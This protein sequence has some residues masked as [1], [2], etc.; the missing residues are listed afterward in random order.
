M[1]SKGILFVISGS[2]GV[3]KG[4]INKK[5]LLFPRPKLSISPPPDRC[6]P[7]E[8]DG[9][10]YYF[11]SNDVFAVKI[12][13]MSFWSSPKYTPLYG[14][15]KK[16]YREFAARLRCFIRD[17]HSGCLDVKKQM[18]AGCLFLFSPPALEELEQKSMDEKDSRQ[19]IQTRLEACHEELAMVKHYDYVVVNDKLDEAVDKVQSII[20]AERCRVKYFKE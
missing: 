8:L 4:T 14:T 20:I 12:K 15:P 13:M 16:G 19:S 1:N 7:G 18:P 2:S 9:R 17:R 10:E 11:L 6:R 5:K 3:G